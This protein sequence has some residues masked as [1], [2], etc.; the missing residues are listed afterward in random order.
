MTRIQLVEPENA[1]EVSQE[2]VEE[3]K[4]MTGGKVINYFKQM[5]VSPASFKRYRTCQDRSRAVPSIGR[6]RSQ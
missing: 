3:G 1:P 6:C 2:Y 5:S 4:Q